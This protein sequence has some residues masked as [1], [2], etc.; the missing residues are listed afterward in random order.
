MS[1]PHKQVRGTM[2]A[3]QNRMQIQTVSQM[4][5]TAVT[6]QGVHKWIPEDVRGTQI[7]TG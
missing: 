1:A 6:I 5:R 3:A 2:M 7:M 4:I